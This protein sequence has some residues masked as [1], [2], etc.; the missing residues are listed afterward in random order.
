MPAWKRLP[1]GPNGS[2]TRPSTGHASAIGQLGRSTS[3]GC[4][5]R[6]P[7]NAVRL[8]TGPALEVAQRN[9]RCA[10]RGRR[11]S[12]PRGSRARRAGTGARRRPS[13][14]HRGSATDCR[15]RA[16][17][18]GRAPC[19]SPTPRIP[20]GVRPARRW[21]RLIAA[22]VPGPLIAVDRAGVEPARVQRYLQ[23]GEARVTT[24]GRG[25][26]DDKRDDGKRQHDE[27]EAA[28][29]HTALLSDGSWTNFSASAERGRAPAR[30]P[31]RLGRLA[32]P[33][34]ARSFSRRRSLTTF[35]FALPPVSFITWPTKKPS[36][37]SL[38][39]R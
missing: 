23:R 21:K 27:P 28:D 17:R 13:R 10:R 2:P 8:E 4:V 34:Q 29:A 11:R 36:R 7:G 25:G 15:G 37:P 9:A 30:L 12:W 5:G 31:E 6:R 38:P 22:V 1:R 32:P 39:P 16:A 24:G 20:S 35:G 19:A 18:S 33:A 26:C 14:S 3:Q